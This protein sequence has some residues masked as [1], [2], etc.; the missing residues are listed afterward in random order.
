ML[1]KSCGF[2]GLSLDRF[3]FRTRNSL[4]LRDHLSEEVFTVCEGETPGVTKRQIRVFLH[5]HTFS[6]QSLLIH[7]CF[8]STPTNIS[9]SFLVFVGTSEVRTMLLIFPWSS[10]N[11]KSL[12]SKLIFLFT[13]NFL[14]LSFIHKRSGF[15]NDDD[16]VS[17]A[18]TL[19]TIRLLKRCFFVVHSSGETSTPQNGL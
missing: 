2:S 13:W 15:D 11:R 18:S 8:K 16:K 19:D 6:T 1:L 3:P 17:G 12:A 9:K 14:N 7:C 10:C 4:M 5:L